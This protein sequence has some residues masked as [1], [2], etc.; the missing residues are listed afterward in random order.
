M[1]AASEEASNAF[2]SFLLKFYDIPK[3]SLHLR[4]PHSSIKSSPTRVNLRRVYLSE[5]FVVPPTT[6]G[7]S[8]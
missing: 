2:I 7:K 8:Q 6:S 1:P 5:D 4:S 3:E